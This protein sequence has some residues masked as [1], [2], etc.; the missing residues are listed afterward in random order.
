MHTINPKCEIYRHG[1]VLRET[2]NFGGVLVGFLFLVFCLFLVGLLFLFFF[3]WF[4]VGLSF[5]IIAVMYKSGMLL[6]IFSY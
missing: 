6:W 4:L 1:S 3:C 2:A 5:C